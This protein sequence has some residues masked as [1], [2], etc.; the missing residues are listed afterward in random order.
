MFEHVA[1]TNF[2]FEIETKLDEACVGLTP[3]VYT[4]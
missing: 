4:L 2:T 1:Q 3:G